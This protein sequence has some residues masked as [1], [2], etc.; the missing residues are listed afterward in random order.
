MCSAARYSGRRTADALAR[1][2]IVGVDMEHTTVFDY[3]RNA[4]LMQR[5]IGAQ[6]HEGV[7]SRLLTYRSPFGERRVAEIIRPATA[8]ARAASLYVHWYEPE[9]HDSNRTQFQQ[10]ATTMAKRGI[11]SL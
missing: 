6:E 1:L 5:E 7:A 2:Q 10:E 9:S 8:A 3:D 4:T 11:V